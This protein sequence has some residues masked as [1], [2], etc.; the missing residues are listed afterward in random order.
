M[1]LRDLFRREAA[2]TVVFVHIPKTG[3]TSLREVLLRQYPARR[4]FW[5]V[6]PVKDSA[7]LASLPEED[8]ARLRL[9]EGHM[10]Y[11]VHELLPRPCVYMTMLREP[12]ERVL[13]YYSHIRSRED[14]FLH[15]TARDLSLGACI[16]R[17]LTVEL[18]N[19]MVRAL[20]SLGHVNVPV[21]GVTRGMLEEAKAHLE[22]MVV[23][24]TER[25]EESLA[26]FAARLGWRRAAAGRANV[27]ASRVRR[28]QLARSEL[29]AVEACN[30][31]DA[32]LYA[33]GRELFEAQ[34]LGALADPGTTKNPGLVTGVLQTVRGR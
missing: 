27:S 14:H 12:V 11:G 33:Y 8:R 30:A 16:E 28:E 17:G 32:E 7:W 24:L 18:D 34:R 13:S 26:M 19:F 9:V 29:E 2:F 4:A 10:Y 1:R 20:S 6:D 15:E 21:G 23:G 25:F 31:L 22:G 3:G 5:I